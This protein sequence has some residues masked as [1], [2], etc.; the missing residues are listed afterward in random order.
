MPGAAAECGKMEVGL[1]GKERTMTML[2]EETGVLDR[3]RAPL[4]TVR[5][6]ARYLDV[7]ERTFATLGARLSPP[8]HPAPHGCRV[9]CADDA[10]QDR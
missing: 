1:S 2:D 9:T 4:Y 7:P 10:A 3:F 8:V 5:E 6:A